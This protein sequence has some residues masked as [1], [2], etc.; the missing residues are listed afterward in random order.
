MR[1]SNA[2]VEESRVVP[3]Y[4]FEQ[5]F[6]N[7][8]ELTTEERA[9]LREQHGHIRTFY[10]IGP[11]RFRELQRWLNQSRFGLTYDV[12]LE[13]WTRYALGA[14]VAGLVLGI[15]LTVQF[16]RVGA[17]EFV[18][19]LGLPEPVGSTVCS[20]LWRN[21]FQYGSS[22]GGSSLREYPPASSSSFPSR[23][24]ATSPHSLHPRR[25]RTS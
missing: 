5:Y 12:Y 9:L 3:E 1:N 2:G 8:E 21:I 7:R 18:G 24:R 19:T 15:L 11:D 22:T 20:L 6:P 4:E 25:W 17:L 14:A 16:A 23:I 13:R 10:R